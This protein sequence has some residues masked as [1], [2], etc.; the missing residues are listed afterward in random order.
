M[1]DMSLKGSGFLIDSEFFR[2]IHEIEDEHVQFVTLDGIGYIQTIEKSV[3]SEENKGSEAKEV[4]L[5]LQ[6]V[7]PED[8]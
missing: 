6:A 8:E 4:K 1:Q 3:N 7:N 2:T 5:R